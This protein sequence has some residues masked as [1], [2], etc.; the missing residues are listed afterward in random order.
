MTNLLLGNGN[1][2]SSRYVREFLL[3]VEQLLHYSLVDEDALACVYDAFFQHLDDE[4]VNG[5]VCEILSHLTI[6]GSSPDLVKRWRVDKLMAVRGRTGAFPE[7]DL[8]L[9]I[10]QALRPDLVTCSLTRRRPGDTR[11]K[12]KARSSRKDYFDLLWSDCRQG[13]TIA[14]G[15]NRLVRLLLFQLG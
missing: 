10:Y 1:C 5:I 8:L 4:K 3:W 2:R 15:K 6:N 9:G 11:G 7:I 14:R 12:S 13:V